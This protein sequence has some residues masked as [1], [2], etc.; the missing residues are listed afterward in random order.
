MSGIN[1]DS[2]RMSK[3]TTSPL[4]GM[5][6]RVP[7]AKWTL[8]NL[9][10]FDV[11]EITV[12]HYIKGGE[13]VRKAIRN[14]VDR[15]PLVL[16]GVGL[17][18]GT[19]AHLD[20]AYLDGVAEAIENLKT[21]SYSEHLAWTKV[22]DLDLA[23]LL[24]LPKT[25]AVADMLIPKI[26][27]IQA[28][29]P[30]PFSIENISYVFD[31]PEREMNDAEFFNLLFRATGVGMLLDVENLFV[32]SK[33]HG[34]DPL[35]FL[36]ELPEDVVTGVHAAGGPLI[37]RPYLDEPFHADNHGQQVPEEA[38]GLLGHALYR[39]H[40]Q[41]IILERDNDYEK[42][43]ELLADVARIREQVARADAMREAS[44]THAT[45]H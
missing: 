35:A 17:S 43:D 26:E 14:L 15:I 11:L 13:F 12:D 28:R 25:Q 38:L 9:H 36:D 6:F 18:L 21:P 1:A 33:N 22:P 29:L 40:P 27:R 24:P 23:N 7:I 42:G 10:R 45:A 32:N 31:F 41:T 39:Q 8:A 20:E 30:V 3:M 5:G 16:H 19:D 44:V 4:V 2:E 34:I 37:R